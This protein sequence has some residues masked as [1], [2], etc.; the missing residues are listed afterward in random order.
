MTP[1]PEHGFDTTLLEGVERYNPTHT[2]LSEDFVRL[3]CTDPSIYDL[4]V[5]QAVLKLCV[6]IFHHITHVC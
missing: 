3:E 4:D 2:S 1:A 5:N 6:T